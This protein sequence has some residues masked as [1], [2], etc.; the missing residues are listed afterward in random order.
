MNDRFQQ[1]VAWF[2]RR[3]VIPRPLSIATISV[4][5]TLAAGWYMATAWNISSDLE[6][7]LDEDSEAATAM[8]ELDARVG[9][10]SSL[11]AV[12][13]SP[14]T[15]ANL[16]FAG[17]YAEKLRELP[18]VDLAHFH[19]DKTFFENH[20]LLY[21]D[22]ETLSGLHEDIQEDIE[23]AKKKANPLFVSLD[24]EESEDDGGV[25]E[26]IDKQKSDLKHARYKEY[27]ISDDGYSVTILV[28]FGDTD[29]GMASA[30]DLVDKVERVGQ[31]LDP[32][33]Y[34]PDMQLE[35]GG[36][37][38]DRNRQYNSVLSDVR[39]S[40]LFTLLGV[41]L[42]IAAYF[43]RFRAAALVLVPLVMSAIWTLAIAFGIFGKLSTISV[44][45][46]AIILGLGID[47]GIHLLSRFDEQ[48]AAHP[49]P[50]D[51]VVGAFTQTGLATALGALTTFST[52]LILSFAPS[53]GLSEFGMVASIG[54]LSTLTGM[55]VTLPAMILGYDDSTGGGAAEGL[56]SGGSAEVDPETLGD[57]AMPGI[58]T[59]LAATVVLT[60]GAI[61]I[62]P[63]VRFEQNLNKVGELI[64]IWQSDE[65]E[66]EDT[67]TEAERAAD[68]AT[69]EADA[70]A[71]HLARRARQVRKATAPDS[72]QPKRE[73][74]TV[75]EKYT[76]ATGGQ[77]S[78][79]PTVL[80][81]D[82][83]EDA[84]TTHNYLARK[85]EA[86]ELETV[87]SVNSIY[88]FV[89]G[90]DQ[91]QKERLEQIR[92]IDETLESEDLSVL[93]KKKRERLDRYQTSLDVR[94]PVS[95]YDLPAWTK[96]LF[97]EAGPEGFEAADG[98]KF[99]FEYVIYIES[100]VAGKDGEQAR[101][102]LGDL[103]DAR[104]TLGVDFRIASPASVYVATLDQVRYEGQ[105]LIG[106]ALALV[107][108]L[109]ISLFQ[110][111]R[112]GLTAL[113]PLAVGL[114]WTLAVATVAGVR[115]DM[116]NVVIL[117]AIIGIGIDD[118]IHFY[119]RYLES[120]RGSIAHTFRT[121]GTTIVMT[122]LTSMVGFGGLT[123]ADYHGVKSIGHLAVAGIFSTL[124]ATL[125][126]MPT[127]LG[128][129]ERY[130]WES[131]TADE[132]DGDE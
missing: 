27:L 53:R 76:S 127:V 105:Y 47:Y 121:V 54:V 51:A 118:G 128:L 111:L 66:T 131:I 50:H 125:V 19:N 8:T 57:I 60:A 5:L 74:D 110:S 7:L 45:I 42:L 49:D 12:I 39:L 1:F 36:G 65:G 108:V 30:G 59:G 115:L 62:L 9:S 67:R 78:S 29:G 10:T 87:G 85:L 80:L 3:V 101:Q 22:T 40:A 112:R 48:Y 113:L 46:F 123:L 116:F 35:F 58:A 20:L 2:L 103:T 122:S 88:S 16:E 92:A 91:E 109:L 94:E 132:V 119:M 84:R 63:Q 70:L 72:F 43:R 104:D 117:P 102:F 28:R 73:Q 34:H 130:G 32:T 129:A 95:I 31:E 114:V 97:R 14:D 55:F 25:E 120:G 89:P 124:L 56:L 18:E 24:D 26:T 100:A 81:F 69:S 33:S 23:Q 17:K 90:T 68:R 13:D 21:F 37:M 75:G 86:G 15:D 98:E 11:Y 96:R 106:I 71:G 52:F 64:P 107:L 79:A 44:F 38:V 126:V 82:T 83:A 93:S 61:A 4:V 41:F 99:A 6:S 77:M